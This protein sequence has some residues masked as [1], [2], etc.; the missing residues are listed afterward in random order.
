MTF[1]IFMIGKDI[2]EDYGDNRLK[3]G[4]ND[5]THNSD[6]KRHL[7]EITVANRVIM[8]RGV[9]YIYTH[10]LMPLR[11]SPVYTLAQ[12]GFNLSLY[13]RLYLTYSRQSWTVG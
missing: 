10:T 1:C 11:Y 6:K 2:K 7:R 9:V 3:S 12:R 4:I 8:Q 13:G 5:T